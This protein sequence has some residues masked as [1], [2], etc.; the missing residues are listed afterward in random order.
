M[1]VLRFL[2]L[3]VAVVFS[4]GCAAPPSHEQAIPVDAAEVWPG[5]ASAQ[6]IRLERLERFSSSGQFTLKW[7]EGDGRRW[8]Q[9][10]LRIWWRLPE[11]M[12]LRLTRVG[13]RLAVAGWNDQTWWLFDQLGEETSLAIYDA[14]QTGVGKDLLLSPPLLLVLAGLAPFPEEP[15]GD[16]VS[17]RS[18]VF[19]FSFSPGDST[20]R[21]QVVVD[22]TGP[23]AV[24]LTDA[25][26]TVHARSELT[27]PRPVETRGLGMGAWPMLPFQ[28]RVYRPLASGT[29]AQAVLSIDRPQAGAEVKVPERMFS[30][31]AL[32]R[33]LKPSHIDDRRAGP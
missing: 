11:E 27:D 30:L 6:A 9:A 33:A 29:D 26:G 4:A 8:E 14:S 22:K 13:T 12:A 24:R 28:I 7:T 19:K 1:R 32:K 16:L 10:D 2:L 15:P 31:E 18:G 5:L 23:T 21:V 25:T 20:S 3:M 17:L